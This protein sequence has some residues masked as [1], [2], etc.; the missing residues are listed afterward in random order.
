MFLS[1]LW[2][3]AEILGKKNG[4]F[5]RTDKFENILDRMTSNLIVNEE[6]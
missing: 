1:E 3:I 4:N 5:F 2:V 6:F